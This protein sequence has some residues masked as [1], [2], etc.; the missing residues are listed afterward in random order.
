VSHDLLSLA[1]QPTE[2]NVVHYIIVIREASKKKFKKI[3]KID[4]TQLS[5]TLNTG[6]EDN[7]K[8]VLR[9]YAEN[10]V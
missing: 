6:F 1:W 7:Q 5:C 3:A 4:G 9:V 10:E 2:A 8:Y